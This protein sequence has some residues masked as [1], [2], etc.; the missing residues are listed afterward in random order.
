MRR[1]SLGMKY[2]AFVAAFL[3][4]ALAMAE[5]P[6]PVPNITTLPAGDDNITAVRK[7]DPAPYAG[8]LFDE[9]TSLRWALWLQQYKLRY[10]TDLK[11]A[12]DG[13]K[14]LVAHEDTYRTIEVDRNSKSEKDLRER[15]LAADKARLE[16]EE[17]LRNPP[18]WKEPGLWFAVGVLTTSVAAALVAARSK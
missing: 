9:N 15:L 12:Q 8:Q 10:G 1:Y 3:I 17:K 18:F 5:E 13:C 2:R 11:A 4:P 6:L 14:V 16:A 7:G